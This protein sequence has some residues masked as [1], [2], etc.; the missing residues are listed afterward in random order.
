MILKSGIYEYE[1]LWNEWHIEELIGKGSYGEVYKISRNVNGVKQYAA[2]KYISIPKDEDEKETVYNKGLATDEDSL[3]SYFTKMGNSFAK[4]IDLM[5]KLRGSENI[6]RYESHIKNNKSDNIG[7]DIIIRMELLTSLEKHLRFNSF[8]KREVVKL[9]I[10]ICKA[11]EGCQ[12]EKIIHRDVK[13]ENIFIDDSGRY[14]LGDF[15]VSR[16]AQGTTRGT[17]VGTEDY[18]APEMIKR[19]DYNDNVDIYALGIVMYRL[20]NNNRIPFLPCEGE[21]NKEIIESAYYKRVSGRE[22]IPNPKFDDGNLAEIIK[23]ACAFNR[24]QRYQSAKEMEHDLKKI[25][26]KTTDEVVLKPRR[27]PSKE[28]Q[29]ESVQG[30]TVGDIPKGGGTVGDVPS[31][32]GT[33]SDIGNGVNNAQK[34][35]TKKTAIIAA[36]VALFIIGVSVFTLVPKKVPVEQLTG[37]PDDGISLVVGDEKELIYELIPKDT[38]DK[39]VFEIEDDSIATINEEGKIVALKEGKTFVD[40][41]CGAINK[42]LKLVVNKQKIP[43]ESIEG[44][45]DTAVLEIGGSTTINAVVI[46]ADATEQIV[47]YQSSN[48]EVA[49]IGQDGVITGVSAGQTIISASADGKSKQMT[50]TVK[51]KE[52]PKKPSSTTTTKPP[53]SNTK[54]GGTS[55]SNNNNYTPP[56]NNPPAVNNTPPA[57]TGGSNTTTGGGNLSREN[58]G[59]DL[60]VR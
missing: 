34:K 17:F 3:K 12:K 42:Q 11:I 43:V 18:M 8:T 37:L 14:K 24:H 15:G 9:G 33:I 27:K 25:L 29:G 54:T 50:V 2:A 31:G 52:Q 41:S 47:Q 36:I 56:Q 16:E 39:I 7:C 5:M 51:A 19:E 35:N 44:F 59:D 26:E 10:D 22:S 38:T 46:P 20:L 1:P 58:L 6:V 30:G 13:T 60:G 48:P 53:S 49:T 32:G 45:N 23:K 28:P 57:N 21:I 55:G 4:E 40:I